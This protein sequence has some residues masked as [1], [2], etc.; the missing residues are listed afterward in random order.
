MGMPIRTDRPAIMPSIPAVVK[1]VW[2]MVG[3]ASSAIA[4]T[5]SGNIN[6]NNTGTSFI[7]DLKSF[8]HFSKEITQQYS[9]NMCCQ[10]DN[11]QN[12]L[13]SHG[14]SEYVQCC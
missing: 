9:Q 2:N 1:L 12:G 13:C 3:C 5:M 8:D 4:S 14:S 7:T 6:I 11:R 10:G